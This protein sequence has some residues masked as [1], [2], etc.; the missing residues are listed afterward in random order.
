VNFVVS[1][2]RQL[3]GEAYRAGDVILVINDIDAFL[4][5]HTEAGR[6]NATEALLPFFQSGLRIVGTTTPQG[7]HSTIGKNSQL[8]MLLG[9]LEIAE[10][11]AGQ[12]L[13]I[14]QDALVFFERSSNIFFSNSAL[15]EIVKL[16]GKLIQNLPN[17]EKSLE[18][19]E[20]VAVY[21]TSKTHDVVVRKEHVQKVISIR[22][23]VPVEKVAGEERGLLLN[24]EKVLHERIVGQDEAIGEIANTMRRARAGIRSEKKPI[25]SFLFLGPTGVGKT[26]TTKALASVYFGSEKNIIRFD[27]S[28]FQQVHSINRLIGDADKNEGGLLT[29]A[30][31]E[32]PFSLVL[33]DEIEKAHPKV[34]D[35]F[36]QVFDEGRLTDAIGRTVSFTNAIFIATSNAGAEKIREMVKGG[37]DPSDMR[38]EI[39]DYL[40]K[41]GIFRPEF[42]NRFDA[43]IIFRPLSAKELRE[44]VILLLNELNERLAEKEIQVAI[45]PELADAIALHAFHPEF[46]ARPVRRY[47]QEHLENYVASKLLSDQIKRGQIVEIPIEMIGK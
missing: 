40:Q 26:E 5:P 33:L 42:L 11:S 7:Y 30:I 37:S 38:E 24:L 35:L 25:G 13:M 45:T 19:L 28:E 29:E 15:K 17:P 43:V 18:V 39:L 36:L 4:D 20:E 2:I 46:G 6:V 12:T 1:K 47:I 14:L 9:K 34:L 44:V 8:S 31:M 21:V 23:K 32:K 27:M 10:L 22:T 3:F 41:N 16:A